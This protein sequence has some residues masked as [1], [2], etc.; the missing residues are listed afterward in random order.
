MERLGSHH[1]RQRAIVC[2][3]SDD[4]DRAGCSNVPLTNIE[5][6]RFRDNRSIEFWWWAEQ[7]L[8]LLLTLLAVPCFLFPFRRSWQK[9][10]LGIHR[11]A[12]YWSVWLGATQD[13]QRDCVVVEF[14]FEAI[15]FS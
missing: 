7:S 12:Y 10:S 15:E 5:R 9:Q 14:S 3:L 8:C 11:R 4:D 13:S 2:V 6:T 1:P